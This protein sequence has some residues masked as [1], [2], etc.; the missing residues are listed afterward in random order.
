[1]LLLADIAR[2]EKEVDDRDTIL[3]VAPDKIA[4]WVVTLSMNGD[5]PITRE[6]QASIP[7]LPHPR[8]ERSAAMSPVRADQ[9]RNT[10]NAAGSTSRYRGPRRGVTILAGVPAICPGADLDTVLGVPLWAGATHVVQ[11]GPVGVE[12]GVAQGV[13]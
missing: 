7:R 6:C 2:G 11:L 4:D 5:L 9:G 12:Q 3:A 10:R 13:D 1:M 8:A